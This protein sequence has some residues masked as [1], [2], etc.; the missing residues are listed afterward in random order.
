MKNIFR[1]L[2]NSNVDPLQIMKDLLVEQ[3]FGSTVVPITKGLFK[4]LV[5]E[6]DSWSRGDLVAIASGNYESEV[7]KWLSQNG[8]FETV[9]NVG[10]GT[11]YYP[12]GLIHS[13]LA[14]RAILFEINSNSRE[15]ARANSTRN[16]LEDFCDFFGEATESNL[17]NIHPIERMLLIVDIEGGEFGL[18]TD[19]VLN[20]FSNCFLVIEIHDFSDKQKSEYI[21]LLGRSKEKFHVE[22]IN[23]S[24]RNPHEVEEILHLGENSRWLLMSEGRP[25]PMK[26]LTLSPRT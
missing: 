8:P 23:Q 1:K 12:L 4:G 10:A 3:N 6:T 24:E 19:D 15:I 17:L 14:N 11:G 13:N 26:W 18:F 9:V 21:R 25:G 16:G 2:Q 5:L 22:I 20:K 7:Q